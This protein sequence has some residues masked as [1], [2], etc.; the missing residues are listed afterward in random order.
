[1]TTAPPDDATYLRTQFLE[2]VAHE[3]RG[4]LGVIDGAIQ[5]LECSLGEQAANHQ[6]LMDMVRRGIRRLAR[7]ADRLQQTGQCERD[8]LELELQRCDLAG[9]VR[10]SVSEAAA[11]EGRKM[12]RVQ[13]DVPVDP[14]FADIDE[15]WMRVALYEIASNA[16]RHARE[17]V[18]VTLE[19]TEQGF[20]V[21]FVDDNRSPAEFGP[22]R[23]RPPREA[24][25]LGLAL[26]IVRDVVAAHGGQLRIERGADESQAGSPGA[27]AGRTRVSLRIPTTRAAAQ[28]AEAAV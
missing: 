11:T 13:L 6:A 24:R 20:D 9:L 25:G 16:I 18:T 23:F 19:Q 1:M 12:I 26:A 14:R 4:P 2:R 7:T 21:S 17:Q 8:R 5:E 27:S 10:G 15:R 28:P 3:L 22:L